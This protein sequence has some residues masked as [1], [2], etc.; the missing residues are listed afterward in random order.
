M[1]NLIIVASA[2]A[3]LSVAYI[4]LPKRLPPQPK[5]LSSSLQG[6]ELSILVSNTYLI[7][8]FYVY[9]MILEGDKFAINSCK[10]QHARARILAE[11][12]RPFDVLAFQ[13]V[14]GGATNVLQR[15]IEESHSI[16]PRYRGWEGF[17]GSGVLSEYFNTLVCLLRKNGGLW[18]AVSPSACKTRWLHH[19]TF[20]HNRGEEVMNKSVTFVLLDVSEKWGT[21]RHLLLINTHL[22]SPQPF[23]HTEDRRKQRKEISSILAGLPSRLASEGIEVDWKKCAALLVGDLNTAFCERDDRTGSHFTKEYLET[24][25]EFDAVDLY[26]ENDSFVAEDLGKFSYDGEANSYVSVNSRK[27]SSRMDY[28]LALNSLGSGSTPLLKLRATSCSILDNV[29]CSDHWPIAVK[30]APAYN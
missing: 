21:G 2:V 20:E 4:F 17:L 16:V 23:S 30:V 14:W 10:D 22:H 9:K 15:L 27:D 11:L 8:W 7:P 26:L 25:S 19:H 18:V 13:E 5:K 12:A 28:A 24:L 29:K 1:D 3:I 6:N